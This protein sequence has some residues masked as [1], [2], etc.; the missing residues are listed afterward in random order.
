M[1]RPYTPKAPNQGTDDY[2]CF[3]LDPR[4]TEDAY[5]T[6]IDVVPGDPQV[7]HHVIL[8][9]VTPDKV[10]AAKRVDRRAPG[11]GWTCFGGSGL[12]DQG[13][14]L[15][16]APW[17]GAW[18]P[19]GGERAMAPDIGI[20][21]EAGSMIV[22][23]VHYNLLAGTGADVSSARLR[24]ASGTKNLAAL[25]TV[26]LPAPVELPCRNG[27]EG[28]LCDRETALLDVMGRFGMRS[29]QAVAGLQLLCNGGGRPEPGTMQSC[30][31]RVSEPATVRAV[32][33]HMHLLGKAIKIEVNPGRRDARTLLDTPVWDFDDQGA[34]PLRRPAKLE[35][36]DELKVTCTH[37]QG[38]R[39]LLPAFEGQPERY[40]LWGEGTTD[41]MCLG[42][43]LVTRP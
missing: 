26:L 16:N 27:V 14:S 1:P 43:V 30:V 11:Q 3:L 5:L 23:Q 21:V 17:L 22:M 34:Q 9:R 12:E 13:A 19:G 18:A 41:E 8:F 40:V 32:A 35:P 42:I 7:V 6:G 37:D 29:G 38:L 25:E 15:D 28:R 31:R 4:L 39:D 36:G 20:P 24:L 33:G 2:R 10:E